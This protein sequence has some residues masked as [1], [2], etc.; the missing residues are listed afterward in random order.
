MDPFVTG[1][2]IIAGSN[3]AGGLF[4]EF[5][6]HNRNEASLAFGREQLAAQKEAL[7]NSIQWR[8][9]D[10][11][12]A[13]IHPLYAL[14]NPGIGI[15]PVNVD[16]GGPSYGMAEALSDMGS[17]IGRGVQAG[18]TKEERYAGLLARLGLER[19]ELEND[20]LRSQIAT[21][22]SQLAPPRPNPSLPTGLPPEFQGAID[23]KP[24]EVN[25]FAS[26][27]NM[28]QEAGAHPGVSFERTPSGGFR[29]QMAK[30]IG[31]MEAENPMA[32]EW[33]VRNRVLPNM[34]FNMQPPPD[35]YL[36]PQ[37]E[38]WV[39]DTWEQEWRPTMDHREEGF[40]A[41]GKFVPR[42]Q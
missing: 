22:N 27:S 31:E 39:W 19:A 20:L 15:S 25:A 12:A 4:G 42:R 36:G 32:L 29:P 23:V 33:F 7:Q 5:G 40:L 41:R 38:G 17:N 16:F 35:S 24:V 37:H 28:N 10:A 8:T 30:V 14:G 11:K 9:A 1:S 6:A 26:E 34:G 18:Q 13:G 2:M 3:L 21:Q